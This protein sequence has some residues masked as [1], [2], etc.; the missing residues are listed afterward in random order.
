M[1]FIGQQGAMRISVRGE[2]TY[3]EFGEN[4]EGELNQ[5][6]YTVLI[7]SIADGA[8]PHFIIEKKV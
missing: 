2:N 3:D 7:D 6:V 4:D 8:N 1:K 5:G